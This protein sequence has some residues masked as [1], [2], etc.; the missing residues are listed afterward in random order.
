MDR[1]PEIAIALLQAPRGERGWSLER[2]AAR[3]EEA[4]LE[5]KSAEAGSPVDRLTELLDDL[6]QEMRDQFEL[7]RRLRTSAEGMIDGADEAAAKAARADVKAAT[8]AIALIVRTLEK[9]DSLKRQLARDRED[10]AL[11]SGEGEDEEEIRQELLRIIEVRAEARAEARL[12]ASLEARMAE[13]RAGE[14]GGRGADDAGRIAGTG[15]P[16]PRATPGAGGG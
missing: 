12:E 4:V 13:G 1:D 9:I 7:F 10:A 3:A 11:A 5:L 14:G 8:D 2:C 16:E 6:T 15:P